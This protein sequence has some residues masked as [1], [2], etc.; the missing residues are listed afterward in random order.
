M[1]YAGKDLDQNNEKTKSRF[2]KFLKKKFVIKYALKHNKSLDYDNCIKL[3]EWTDI[4][5]QIR[6]CDVEIEKGECSICLEDK[7]MAF[8]NCHC[9]NRN[10]CGDCFRKIDSC[11]LCRKKF[12]N[13]YHIRINNHF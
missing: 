11:P 10:V 7:S 2:N 4:L 3:N 1:K 9:K 8:Y 12:P 6:D 5:E 13:D